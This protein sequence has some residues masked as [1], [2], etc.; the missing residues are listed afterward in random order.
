MQE[1]SVAEVASAACRIRW[2][3]GPTGGQPGTLL[4]VPTKG[5]ISSW[6][7]LSPLDGQLCVTCKLRLSR[8]AA[9]PDGRGA[10]N[11]YVRTIFLPESFSSDLEGV[12]W[13]RGKQDISNLG[14]RVF[15]PGGFRSK[16]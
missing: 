2:R 1:E 16:G 15:T 8:S 13:T 4:S 3:L 10:R 14:P 11:L 9:D 5:G 6:V 12:R 7:R